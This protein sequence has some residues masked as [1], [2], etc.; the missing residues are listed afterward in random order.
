MLGRF[1]I[2][3]GAFNRLGSMSAAGTAMTSIR[4]YRFVRK[5]DP[6]NPLPSGRFGES[7]FKSPRPMKLATG[8]HAGAKDIP[9][10]RERQS[11]ENTIL[12]GFVAEIYGVP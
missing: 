1:A 3:S 2:K 9:G 8:N 10:T 6:K 5:T 7:W 4:T 11:A 12:P